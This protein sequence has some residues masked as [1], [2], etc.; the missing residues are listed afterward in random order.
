MA[1]NVI[2][3]FKNQVTSDLFPNVYSV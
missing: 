1:V 3:L 2:L